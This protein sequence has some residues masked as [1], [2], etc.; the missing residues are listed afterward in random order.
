MSDGGEIKNIQENIVS[1]FE[2]LFVG[3]QGFNRNPQDYF[4]AS[5][6]GDTVKLTSLFDGKEYDCRTKNDV[7]RSAS[8]MVK[9]KSHY[10][11]LINRIDL[12]HLPD[13]NREQYFTPQMFNDLCGQH[14][15][16]LKNADSI[17]VQDYGDKKMAY[18]SF[19][20]DASNSYAGF[21]ISPYN[22]TNNEYIVGFTYKDSLSL[23]VRYVVL[24]SDNL[25][26][27]IK[28]ITRL[29]EESF[30]AN[31]KEGYM[32]N[33]DEAPKEQLKQAGLK[34][35]DL[36]EVQKR[37]LLRG[38]ETSVITVTGKNDKGKKTFLRGHLQLQRTGASTADFMFRK[39]SKPTRALKINRL[40]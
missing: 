38:K 8:D 16:I 10:D 30:L 32:F 37:D 18:I 36:S 26:K 2:K 3:L 25:E 29:N 19:S 39:A 15:D 31:K 27:E 22:E 9:Q 24:C 34:W 35:N 11:S 5:T 21:S 23:P 17:S 40:K 13:R 33:E 1:I 6:I 12:T 20:K 14:S 7:Q 28:N 4:S